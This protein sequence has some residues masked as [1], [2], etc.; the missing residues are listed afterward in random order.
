M[1]RGINRIDHIQITA[2]ET[3][4]WLIERLIMI[5]RARL[6]IL[7]KIIFTDTLFADYGAA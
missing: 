4:V 6:E 1:S 7:S 2:A 5:V 3:L